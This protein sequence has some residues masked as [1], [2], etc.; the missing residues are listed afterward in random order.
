M[1]FMINFK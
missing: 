1:N